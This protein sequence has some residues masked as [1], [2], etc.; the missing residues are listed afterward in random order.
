MVFDSVWLGEI[1]GSFSGM[2]IFI[3]KHDEKLEKNAENMME[4]DGKIMK[5]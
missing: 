4:N 5:D 1:V 3:G 2:I